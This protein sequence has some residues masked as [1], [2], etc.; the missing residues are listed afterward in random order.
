MHRDRVIR[1]LDVSLRL[2]RPYK[3]SVDAAL[4]PKLCTDS[5]FSLTF[6]K[7]IPEGP[8]N[9]FQVNDLTF[10]KKCQREG[11]WALLG[12]SACI[13][14]CCGPYRGF[15][16][17]FC[18]GRTLNLGAYP[19]TLLLNLS[20][21]S[22]RPARCVRRE[23]AHQKMQLFDLTGTGAADR[24]QRLRCVSGTQTDCAIDSPCEAPARPYVHTLRWPFLTV[25]SQTKQP[26]RRK[27]MSGRTK[28][29][30]DAAE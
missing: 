15:L 5:G 2:R 12:S 8:C 28:Q 22:V 19:Q 17:A 4:Y 21:S 14:V 6:S 16:F 29:H 23:S 30:K 13:C 27:D 11:N 3:K 7:T 26:L 1:D 10:G 9:S 18:S 24:V 25:L 20:G